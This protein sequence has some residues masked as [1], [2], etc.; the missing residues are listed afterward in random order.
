[1]EGKYKIINGDFLE[2]D[3]MF[4]Y[5]IRALRDIPSHG[6]K[7][8]DV[9]GW[10]EE[11]DNLSQEGCAWVGD[12]AKVYDGGIVCGN[13]IACGNAQVYSEAGLF[14]SAKLSGNA[15][16]AHG[17]MVGETAQLKDDA[18]IKGEIFVNKNAVLCGNARF[19]GEA[20]FSTDAY[21]T[22]CDDALVIKPLGPLARS[23]TFYKTKGG[24]VR[25]TYDGV[26]G[27]METLRRWAHEAFEI[28]YEKDFLRAMEYA[29]GHFGVKE[30]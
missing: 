9:G 29:M 22:S 18:F 1:M 19:T 17:A 12:D 23:I 8:G 4:L 28:C 5:R 15:V 14:A 26:E 20:C 7:A 11:E 30:G 2:L 25:F 13:A 3:G 10:I 21:V 27:S 24:E 16:A 6:V